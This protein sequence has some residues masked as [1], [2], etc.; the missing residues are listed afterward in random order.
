MENEKEDVIASYTRVY[1]DLVG[2]Q[3]D[4]EADALQ[5]M[6]DVI[7]HRMMELIVFWGFDDTAAK[8]DPELYESLDLETWRKVPIIDAD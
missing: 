3:Q 8:A 7:R 5:P 6:L 4:Y 2:I 1:Q